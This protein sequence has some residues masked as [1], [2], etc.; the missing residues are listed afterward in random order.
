MDTELCMILKIYLNKHNCPSVCLYVILF[1]LCVIF[2]CISKKC[3][4]YSKE[5]VNC[6]NDTSSMK[7]VNW[8]I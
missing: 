6:E 1:D 7:G 3:L 4:V 8:A 5:S 2:Q